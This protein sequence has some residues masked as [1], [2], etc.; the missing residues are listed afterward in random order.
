M[1]WDGDRDRDGHTL[2]VFA[3]LNAKVQQSKA[4][5]VVAG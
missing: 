5:I 4:I 3:T 1:G 2:E